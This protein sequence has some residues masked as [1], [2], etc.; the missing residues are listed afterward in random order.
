MYIQLLKNMLVLCNQHL[1]L[2]VS[3]LAV[4]EHMLYNT[5]FNFRQ[6]VVFALCVCVTQKHFSIYV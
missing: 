3:D 5:P 4:N 2:N 1:K 6:V